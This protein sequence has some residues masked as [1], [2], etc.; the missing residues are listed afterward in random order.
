MQKASL[1]N[2]PA[3]GGN[4]VVIRCTM[5]TRKALMQEDASGNGGVFQGIRYQLPQSINGFG[6]VTWGPWIEVPPNELL[7]PVVFEGAPGD[8]DPHAPPIGNGGSYPYPVAPGGPV[9][10]GTPL[11]QAT[12]VSAN[13]I[14]VNVTE[15]N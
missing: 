14:T 10:L 8:R 15:W 7:E 1:Y 12:S 9:T 4:P 2:L 6:Q 13:A 5:V 3:N 11:C